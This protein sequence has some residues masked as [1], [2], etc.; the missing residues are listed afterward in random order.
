MRAH[1][2]ITKTEYLAQARVLSHRLRTHRL[3]ITIDCMRNKRVVFLEKPALFFLKNTYNGKSQNST[4]N[5][6]WC[7]PSMRYAHEGL[8]STF[9]SHMR[10]ACVSHISMYAST[11]HLGTHERLVLLYIQWIALRRMRLCRVICE[12]I[13]ALPFPSLT[14]RAVLDFVM[15][16]WRSLFYN[17]S[18]VNVYVCGCGCGTNVIVSLKESKNGQFI[19]KKEFF[20]NEFMHVAIETAF[21]RKN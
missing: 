13:Y 2:T 15:V 5:N 3:Y 14:P 6:Q 7:D 12:H 16:L 11:R 19:F 1:I 9:T 18:P 10:S 8:Y 4:R 20:L 17:K 21:A